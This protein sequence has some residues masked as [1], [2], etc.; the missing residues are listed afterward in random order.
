M[1]KVRVRSITQTTAAALI[2][3][4][5]SDGTSRT[6]RLRYRTTTP[7]GDW[8]GTLTATSGTDSA[9]I[10]LTGLTPGTEYDVQASL[11]GSFP[12]ART[13]Y[14]TFTTLRYPSISSFMAENIGRNG[15]TL[16][17]AI[18][19]SHGEAQTVHIRYRQERYTAWRATQQADT[20]DDIASIRLRGLSSGTEY[21]AEASLDD[22]FPSDGTKS[23]TF[24]TRER[25]DDAVK[26]VT[27]PA[28]ALNIP[29]PGVSPLMLRFVA[30]EGGDNPSPQT[31]SIWNRVQGTMRF[32]LSDQ[33]EWLS[34]QPESGISGGPADRVDI[35]VSV[36]SS[37]L[38]SGQYVDIIGI[39]VSSTGKAPDQVVVVLDVLLPDY[40]RQFVSRAEGGTVVLPDGTVKMV[41]EPL[42]P[43]KDVDIELMKLN[44]QAHGE[45]PGDRE[46][47]VVAIRSNTYPPGGDTPEDVAYSPG[48]A[49]WV[50][51]PA[52]EEI[53][54][55]EGRVRIYS[56]QD[57]WSLV[58][59]RC[60]TDESGSVWAVVDVVR[61]G[62]FA[63]VVDES[64]A[65][66][67]PMPAAL[68]TPAASV[69]KTASAPS[70]RTSLP[71]Q[72]PTPVPTSAPT[73]MPVP[74]AQQVTA[75]APPVMPSPTATAVPETAAPA[76]QAAADGGGPGEMPGTVLVAIGVPMLIG[77]LIVGFLLYRQHRRRN[78]YYTQ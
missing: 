19:D 59:H 55:A 24:T 13:K 5:N 7:R 20:T 65:T 58:E 61:L 67:T 36:D 41:V 72:P 23:V 76:M 31:F 1:S 75:P 32:T 40:V 43:P 14:D 10:D 54:C 69:I 56:V 9:S 27:Q 68:A 21:V 15:A 52:G 51:L 62:A 26:V 71:A 47:V 30:I 11:D 44:L 17:A 16:T 48:V 49:L 77:A 6:V 66:P 12:A 42:A 3:I 2:D 60:V 28:Q 29:L 70:V 25:K 18:A 33:Q 45:P 64:P 4:A 37:D 46:R 57:D 35:T 8:S 39:D 34:Q 38:A 22:S 73:A 53:A 74:V 50:M 78:G 63:L